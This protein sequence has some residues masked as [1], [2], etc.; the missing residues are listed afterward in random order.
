MPVFLL[1]YIPSLI[2]S[3]SPCSHLHV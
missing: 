1:Y 3:I 2:S